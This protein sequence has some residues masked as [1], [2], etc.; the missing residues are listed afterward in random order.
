MRLKKNHDLGLDEAKKRIDDIAVQLQKRF[1]VSADWDGDDLLFSG[2]GING[3]IAV[4]EQSVL[5]DLKLGLS[6][7]FLEGQIRSGI[8]SAMDEHLD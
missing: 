5:V 2:S 1:S 7:M 8:E 3:H 4:D 6:L